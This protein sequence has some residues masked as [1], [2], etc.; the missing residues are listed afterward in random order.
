M[1]NRGISSVEVFHSFEILNS[2]FII[3]YS[4]RDESPPYNTLYALLSAPCALRSN[5]RPLEFEYEYDL[6]AITYRY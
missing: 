1:S 4:G 2:T 6:K 5:P 3:Q